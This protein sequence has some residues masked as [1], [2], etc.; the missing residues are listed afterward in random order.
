MGTANRGKNGYYLTSSMGGFVITHD[1][2]LK[3]NCRVWYAPER[4]LY[5]FNVFTKEFK[6]VEIRYD[7]DDLV[8]HEPGF[9]EESEWLQYCLLEN[10]FNS[11]RDFVD[12]RIT[13]APFD[14][15]RQLK[16]FSNVNAD[17]DGTCGRR[18]YEFVKERIS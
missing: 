3:A 9:S 11:L 12:D 5:D 10:A 2:V 15:E 18:I 8:L 7:Y 1:Q 6:E 13:G 14:R 16:A 17:T 4:K